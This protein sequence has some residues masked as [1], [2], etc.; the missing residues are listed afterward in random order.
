MIF[1]YIHSCLKYFYISIYSTTYPTQ[2]AEVCKNNIRQKFLFLSAD[3]SY[4]NLD[5]IASRKRWEHYG[6]YGLAMMD[7]FLIYC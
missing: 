1:P 2:T 6:A 5:P 3:G 7:S 4:R